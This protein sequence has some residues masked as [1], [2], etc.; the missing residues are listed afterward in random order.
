LTD[1]TTNLFEVTYGSKLYGTS[2]PTSDTDNKVV[3]LPSLDSLLLGKAPRIFKTRVDAD[4]E[5]VAVDKSMPDNG[6]ETE[7]FPL[8]TFVRDFVAGQTYALEIA[9]GGVKNTSTPPE[10]QELLQ[11][12]I[13]KFTNAEVY[14]MVGFA[15]KQTF[16]YVRRGERLNAARKVLAAISA[17]ELK[18]SLQEKKAEYRL[19]DLIDGEKVIDVIAREAELLTSETP[20]NNRVLRTLELNG[21]SYLET[22]SLQTLNTAVKKLIAGYGERT[23]GA[24]EKAVD[25]K[26]MSHAIR[27]YEQAIELLDTGAITF[28]RSNAEY[29]L[30]VKKGLVDMPVIEAHLRELDDTVQRKLKETTLQKRTPE[31]EAAAEEWLLRKLQNLYALA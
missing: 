26:S 9:F 1:Q 21:R 24:A 6:V 22:S 31:L 27:V 20:N 7:Y 14:S 25:Y 16:D 30:S 13:A 3:Y 29:L 5:P 28:P 2:T 11:E 23:T 17:V 19:D 15:M 18:L 10:M 8:Q 4:G 12:L